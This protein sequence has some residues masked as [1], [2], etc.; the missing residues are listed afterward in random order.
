VAARVAISPNSTA[1]PGRAGRV[2]ARTAF[3]LGA[4]AFACALGALVITAP[5]PENGLMHFGVPGADP[6]PEGS[7]RATTGGTRPGEAKVDRLAGPA[8]DVSKSRP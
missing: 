3:R 6:V 1:T 7:P 5:G 4:L 8:P 2:F